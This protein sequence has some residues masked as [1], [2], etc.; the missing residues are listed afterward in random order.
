LQRSTVIHQQPLIVPKYIETSAAEELTIIENAAAFA[1]NGFR[2]QIDET[3]PPGKKVELCAVPFSKSVQFN[4]QD[5]H[6][7]ASMLSESSGSYGDSDPFVSK[8]LLKND[9]LSVSLEKKEKRGGEGSG[10]GSKDTTRNSLHSQNDIDKENVPAS[11]SIAY[12]DDRGID[13]NMSIM[14]TVAGEH[15]NSSSSSTSSSTSSFVR[16]PKLVAMY[17]S[18]ACRSAIMIGTALKPTEMQAVVGK[19][20]QVEQPWN[21]PHGRPTMRHLADLAAVKGKRKLSESFKDNNLF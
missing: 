19:L 5:I 16:L 6:E 14:S 20:E 2:L 17:A 15:E 3:A 9:A 4:E 11:G 13:T 8:L 1:A 21:C 12:A 10:G 18:R 7:L